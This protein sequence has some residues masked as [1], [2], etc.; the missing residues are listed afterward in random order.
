MSRKLRFGLIGLGEIAYKSTGPVLRQT[1]NAEMIVGM[2]PLAPIAESYART[3]G[4]PC[5]T[6][7]EDVLTHPDVDA[8]VISTPHHLHVPLGI[9]AAQ[10]GKHVIVEKPMATTLNDADALIAACKNA[11]VLCSSKEGSVRYQPATAKA[12]ELIAQGAIGELMATQ[13]VGAADKPLSYWSGGYT[14]R[15]QTTWRQS[16]F[17]SGGGVLIMNYIYD[18]YRLRYITGQEIVRVFAEFG[19]YRTPVEVEDFITLTLRY[20]NDA[21]GT[22]LASSCAPGA[23]RAGARGTKASDNRIYGTAGQI[24]FDNNTL[25][26]YTDNEVEGLTRGEWTRL[27]F[28]Q[29][30]DDDAYRLYFDKFAEAVLAGR[31]PDIPAEEG[32]KTLEVVLAAYHSGETHQPVTLPLANQQA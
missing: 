25:L 2:D 21:L 22:W 12:K 28:P 17:E 19:T 11:G 23:S 26:V 7:L 4:I 16:K 8:V 18:F 31:A 24:V 14:G 30:S 27:S 5:S 9:Q 29:Q 3:F 1:A 10:A 13:V 20:A 6:A 15:V 32:R